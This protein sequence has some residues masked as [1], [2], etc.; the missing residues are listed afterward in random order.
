MRDLHAAGVRPW[1]IM[2]PGRWRSEA[3]VMC[4]LML[5]PQ[6][7]FPNDAVRTVH[8]AAGHAGAPAA[9]SGTGSTE[10]SSP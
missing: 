1:E 4:Y 3:D 6:P 9:N 2:A 5:G 10:D 8:G 7:L